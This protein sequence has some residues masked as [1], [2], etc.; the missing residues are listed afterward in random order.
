MTLVPAADDLV[1]EVTAL[2]MACLSG[3]ADRE[4]AAR[5]DTLL[6][7]SDEAC[8]IYV[9]VVFDSSTLR[10]WGTA[11]QSLSQAASDPQQLLAHVEADLG[12]AVRRGEG[13]CEPG[14]IPSA[15]LLGN[16]LDVSPG[17]F[18][19]AGW[20]VAYLVATVVFA[21]A[22]TVGSIIR[23]SQPGPVAVAPGTE[24]KDAA[25]KTAE[26]PRQAVGRITG[27]ANC[28]WEE[29]GGR[30]QGS[31]AANQKSEIISHKSVLH[32]GDILALRSGLLEITY[33]SG[34]RVLLQ[35][36]VKYEVESA[37]GGYLAV[38]RL[39]ARLEEK[40]EVRGQRS[41]IRGQRSEIAHHQFAVRTPTAVVTDLG[42]EFGVKV[43]AQGV[44]SSYVFRGS[45]RLQSVAGKGAMQVVDRV[46]HE[47][48]SA[49]V[50]GEADRAK[51][52]GVA[53]DPSGF[54]REMPKATRCSL[55]LV[56]L[57]IGGDGAGQRRS[58][59]IYPTTGIVTETPLRASP[60]SDDFAGDGK[61]HRV[62]SPV[63]DGVFIPDGRNGAFPVD[64]AG[65][66][67]A[68]FRATAN[69]TADSLWVGGRIRGNASKNEPALLDGIDYSAP[70]HTWLYMHANKGITFNL[71]AIRKAKPGFRLAKF[72]AVAGNSERVS[73]K[74][75]P[76][77]A[78]VWVLV[79]GQTRF[80][81]RE[82]N[83]FSGAFP[84]AIPLREG[85]RFLTL[86]ATD[87]GNGIFHDWII[88]GDPQLE[89][90]PADRR[91]GPRTP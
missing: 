79:D 88:F 39:T 42:T 13:T 64:S 60:T 34:A 54:L 40:S 10:R 5:L 55:N 4:D 58:V 65:H 74:D 51:T 62:A 56:D 67:F 44:T 26:T 87:G 17:R 32:L 83:S 47:N 9:R 86:A 43:D 8:R 49:R 27:M 22:L 48:E 77:M 29:T 35:G 18:S 73:E 84:V 70:G 45:V 41:E 69:T 63:I 12:D 21:I 61:Y 90:A 91:V 38:G 7:E 75:L 52:P 16:G 15:G 89:F 80:N 81:R 33:D 3:D 11:E 23:V 14:Q 50:D 66:T 53:V 46:L 24:A 76:A 25:Q 2:A 30:V 19:F 6:R 20:P 59:A 72:H 78:D 28:V 1:A 71:D 82:I 85:D 68:E 36:P 37:A 57:I 31:G